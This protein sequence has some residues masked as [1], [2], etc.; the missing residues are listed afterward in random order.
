[1]VGLDFVHHR[2][3]LILRELIERQS[4]LFRGPSRSGH[5]FDVPIIFPVL[6]VSQHSQPGVGS[7]SRPELL[8]VEGPRPHTPHILTEAGNHAARELVIELGLLG[9]RVLRLFGVRDH[10]GLIDKLGL[11]L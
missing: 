9:H 4:E 2:S 5:H 11:G 7:S 10:P 6:E 3:S 8:G 1:M